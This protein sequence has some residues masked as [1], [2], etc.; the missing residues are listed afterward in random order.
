M[1]VL[2][3]FSRVNATNLKDQRTN[4]W[5]ESF[6]STDDCCLLQKH[7]SY[8]TKSGTKKKEREKEK[9]EFGWFFGADFHTPFLYEPCKLLV[10]TFFQ[11]RFLFFLPCAPTLCLCACVCLRIGFC[12]SLSDVCLSVCLSV[13]LT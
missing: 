10:D 13:C 12:V 3:C 7:L 11:F 9:K 6:I 8:K 2:H 1:A 4:R 5:L